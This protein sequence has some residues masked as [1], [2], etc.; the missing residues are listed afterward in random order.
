MCGATTGT[1]SSRNQP[2]L[3]YDNPKVKE[4]LLNAARFWLNLGVDGFRVDAVP[5]LIER[6]GTN[7]ENLPETHEILKRMRRMV[8]DEFPGRLL[9]AEA[10]QWPE[11]VVEYFGTEDDPEFHM[12]FNFPVMPRL[13]MSLKKE[14]TT[15]IR[16][17]MDRLP[18]IPSFGQWATFLRNHDELT[19]E[20]V[21][22]EERAFMYA[23]YSP[24]TRMRINVGIRRRLAP[25][26]D[27]ERRRI[28]L[29]NSVLLALPGSPILYYGDEIGMG[30]DLALADRNGVRTPM[31]WNAGISGGFSTAW[32]SDCFFPPISDPVYGYQRVNV[33]VPGTRPQQPAALDLP[34]ARS[35]RPPRLCPRR[36]DLC[37]HRQRLG[38]GL[39]PL[40]RQ[41]NPADRLQLRRQR[42]GRH[43][44]PDRACGPHARYPVRS[45]PLP[46]HHRGRVSDDAGQI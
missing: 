15:S 45:Q 23:S 30:D 16:E 38:A 31:Q 35:P 6:E 22:D 33:T 12:C 28:E 39:H 1:V 2:D 10:N 8:D 7:C 11:D 34:S 37:G 44:G 41:R 43:P 5:Y 17:I 20:M 18:E 9:L 26:L 21:D 46:A 36:P 19:L 4:E 42:P 3:N 24:D 13:Y 40:P 27:N 32:P 25:L 14:D 29:L